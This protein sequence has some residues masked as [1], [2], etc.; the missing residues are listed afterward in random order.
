MLVLC[1]GAMEQRWV[2]LLL[3]LVPW[4]PGLHPCL[5]CFGPPVQWARLCREIARSS[6]K[7]SQHQHCLEALAEAA[8]PLAPVTVGGWWDPR[9]THP[10]VTFCPRAA[11]LTGTLGTTIS[12]G[13]SE[14]HSGGP[15]ACH[16][17]PGPEVDAPRHPSAP[18]GTLLTLIWTPGISGNPRLAW[19]AGDHP[20]LGRDTVGTSSSSQSYPRPRGSSGI[21]DPSQNPYAL[22]RTPGISPSR[23]PSSYWNPLAL[24]LQS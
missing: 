24:S 23:S 15:E 5:L 4:L 19:N 1:S 3:L 7:D 9:D 21:P 17:L 13:R 14:E 10:N 8:V 6:Q 20:A 2:P 22:T 16:G 12:T 18:S 11:A